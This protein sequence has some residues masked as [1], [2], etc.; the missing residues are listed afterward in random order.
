MIIGVIKMNKYVIRKSFLSFLAIGMTVLSCCT[1]AA[2]NVSSDF[3]FLSAPVK[4]PNP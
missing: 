2:G 4:Q 3:L 1:D